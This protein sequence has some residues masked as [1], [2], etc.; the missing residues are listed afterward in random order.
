MTSTEDF[1]GREIS[2]KAPEEWVKEILTEVAN[3]IREKGEKYIYEAD[4]RIA[5]E[6]RKKSLKPPDILRVLKS[7][8]EEELF[9]PAD[10]KR[11]KNRRVFDIDKPVMPPK[12]PPNDPTLGMREELSSERFKIK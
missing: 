2:I 4:L 12:P 7:T 10:Q 3:Q 11:V 6:E 5:L 1:E 9:L 8:Y